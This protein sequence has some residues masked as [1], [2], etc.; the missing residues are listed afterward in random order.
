MGKGTHYRKPCARGA[1]DRRYRT[2]KIDGF[3]QKRIGQ[4]CVENLIIP[5][6]DIRLL[7]GTAFLYKQVFNA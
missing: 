2:F 5:S 7:G 6:G 1:L 3:R 4:V